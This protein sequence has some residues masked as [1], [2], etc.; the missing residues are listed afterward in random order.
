MAVRKEKL[1]LN[2]YFFIKS[3]VKYFNEALN[4]IMVIL[5]LSSLF[6]SQF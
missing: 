2:M 6:L 5:L 1:L 3:Q 4:S